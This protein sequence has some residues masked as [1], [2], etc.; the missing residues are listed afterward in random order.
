MCFINDSIVEVSNED[1]VD[2]F[3][4]KCSTISEAFTAVADRAISKFTKNRTEI[5]H[6]LDTYKQSDSKNVSL[7]TSPKTLSKISTLTELTSGTM[8]K[9]QSGVHVSKLKGDMDHINKLSDDLMISLEADKKRS[10]VFSYS[11]RQITSMLSTLYASATGQR[12]AFIKLKS[13]MP[14]VLD[15]SAKLV[16]KQGVHDGA[17]SKLT[18]AVSLLSDNTRALS[19]LSNILN[20]V[21]K[22]GNKAVSSRLSSKR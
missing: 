22:V 18:G 9:L 21:T 8:T 19:S 20:N 2:W 5:A 6:K 17:R 11:A 16:D 12:A 10:N 14:K 15:S 1:L 7:T 3:K 13:T 4:H